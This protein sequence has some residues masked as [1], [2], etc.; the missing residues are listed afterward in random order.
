MV[1]VFIKGE[2]YGP[3]K[4]SQVEYPVTIKAGVR[5]SRSQGTT[6]IASKPWG[7]GREAGH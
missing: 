6:K 7:A 4:T 5:M 2:I 3:T 1:V